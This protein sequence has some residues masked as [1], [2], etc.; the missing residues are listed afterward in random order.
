MTTKCITQCKEEY[1]TE[2]GCKCDDDYNGNKDWCYTPSC[3]YPYLKTFLGKKYD[4]VDV[5]QQ[6]KNKC[7]DNDN[8][9]I[10]CNY[11]SDNIKLINRVKLSSKL[12]IGLLALFGG[13]GYKVN[14]KL[15]IS[16]EETARRMFEDMENYI[17]REAFRYKTLSPEDAVE[18]IDELKEQY[19]K[20][21]TKF[22]KD[23]LQSTTDT[24]KSFKKVETPLIDLLLNNIPEEHVGEMI[25][26]AHF[27]IE[28]GGKF[29]NNFKEYEKTFQR[30]SSHHP[31][32][33][34]VLHK[35]GT[36]I[37]GTIPYHVLTGL[38]E[39]GNTWVQMEA[40]PFT[41]G[42][43]FTEVLINTLKEDTVNNLYYSLDHTFDFISYK[44]SGKN[45]GPFGASKHPERN[46]I[47]VSPFNEPSSFKLDYLQG[48]YLNWN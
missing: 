10:G 25:R 35:A 18:I 14:T 46:P 43:T 2:N 16:D 37:V 30:I 33:K 23:V 20:N 42:L 21:P 1:I 26:G 40:S 38:D 12:S 29:Y 8:N 11:K 6:A 39:S 41:K 34:N 47:Y 3:N 32:V 36:D 24:L 17:M 7:L 45:I 22:I 31:K 15:N 44:L 5:K 13:L 28:D 19:E 27:I 48:N 4:K 9:L